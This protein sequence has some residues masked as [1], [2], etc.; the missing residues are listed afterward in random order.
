[1]L[2]ALELTPSQQA[3]TEYRLHQCLPAYIP[4]D[5]TIS[6]GAEEN[7]PAVVQCPFSSCKYK[8]HF[9]LNIDF[10][11]ML[12]RYELK[13]GLSNLG[14]KEFEK[15][16]KKNK[17]NI[18]E[19]HIQWQLYEQSIPMIRKCDI[20]KFNENDI[21]LLYDADADADT[22]KLQPKHLTIAYIASQD[23][24]SE[25]EE[26]EKKEKHVDKDEYQKLSKINIDNDSKTNEQITSNKHVICKRKQFKPPR[27]KGTLP[28]RSL[29]QGASKKKRAAF[30]PPRFTKKL[31]PYKPI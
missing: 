16:I 18:C 29:F 21:S 11:I 23:E 6:W 10:W 2:H 20:R 12:H 15:I 3:L 22:N 14:A 27:M 5:T 25:N 1:M 19:L 8:I 30:K 24:C 26:E 13:Y 28:K 7:K 9:L 17:E 31:P 4:I